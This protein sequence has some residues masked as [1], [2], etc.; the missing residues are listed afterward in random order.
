MLYNTLTK[1]LRQPSYKFLRMVNQLFQLETCSK[2][3]I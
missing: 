1:D 3:M 2:Q